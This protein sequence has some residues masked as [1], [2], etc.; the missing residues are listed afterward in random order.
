MSL[1]CQ[2]LTDGGVGDMVTT[3]HVT[4]HVT[5]NERSD[6]QNIVANVITKLAIILVTTNNTHYPLD[7]IVLFDYI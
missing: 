3:V 5:H 4:M 1:A 6:K 7:D 2:P